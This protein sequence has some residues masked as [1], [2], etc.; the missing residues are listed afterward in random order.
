MDNLKLYYDILGLDQSASLEEVERAYRDLLELYQKYQ[1]SHDPDFRL[2]ALEKINQIKISYDE[3]KSHFVENSSSKNLKV[4]D[5]AKN[6][7]ITFL[8]PREYA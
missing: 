1:I 3:V 2:S 8:H 7:N 4:K 6:S 5:S